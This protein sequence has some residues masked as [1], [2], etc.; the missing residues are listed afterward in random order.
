MCESI[1]LLV[2]EGNETPSGDRCAPRET[3]GMLDASGSAARY[4]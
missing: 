2:G 1:A 4:E 3:Y